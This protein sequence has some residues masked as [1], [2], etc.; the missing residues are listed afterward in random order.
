MRKTKALTQ[1]YALQEV[2]YAKML[3]LNGEPAKTCGSMVSQLA[4]A[5]D[6]LEERKRILRGRPLPGS[7]RPEKVRK[8]SRPAWTGPIDLTA[9]AQPLTDCGEAGT[10]NGRE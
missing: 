4:R 3:E 9:D 5:W 7:L 8:T 6:V 2:V 1:C 10:S